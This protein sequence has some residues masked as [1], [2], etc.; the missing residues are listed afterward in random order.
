MRRGIYHIQICSSGPR[1]LS[2]SRCCHSSRA[3][4]GFLLLPA[5]Q[6]YVYICQRACVCRAPVSQRLKF[7]HAREVYKCLPADE[8]PGVQVIISPRGD[9]IVVILAS[10]GTCSYFVLLYIPNLSTPIS[11][12]YAPWKE[13]GAEEGDKHN[14]LHISWS[15]YVAWHSWKEGWTDSW[16]GPRENEPHLGS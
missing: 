13:G 7:P 9:N 14:Y 6:G 2:S 8:N 12:T 3:L 16:F 4:G 11:A 1:E 10:A 15:A 5:V